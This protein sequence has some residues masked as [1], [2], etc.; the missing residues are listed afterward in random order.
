MLLKWMYGRSPLGRLRTG[1]LPALVVLLAGC[2]DL[3][4]DRA[5]DAGAPARA[6]GWTLVAMPDTQNV[7]SSY[8]EILYA[9]TAWIAAQATA[10]DIRYVVQEGDITNDSTDTQWKTADHAFRLLDDKVPYALAMGNH[11]YPGSG[12]VTSRDTSQFDTYFPPSRLQW[13]PGFVGTFEEGSAVNAMYAF[14]AGGQP[15]LIFTLEFGPR[16]AVLAWVAGMLQN[17]PTAQAILV[18][19]AYLFPDGSRFDHVNRTD[20]YNNPH[21][22]NADGRLGAVNDAEEMWQKLIVDNPAIRLVLCGHM[23]GEA[24]LTSTRAAGPPVHQLLADFQ[25]ESQGGAGYLRMLTFTL[26]GTVSVWT[27]SPYLDRYRTESESQFTL[28]L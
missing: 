21:D 5:L 3:S 6:H 2:G 18:T 25:S 20:Q 12:T 23:H 27:Y 19:H 28:A 13:Q 8:P 26:G 24:R 4:L 1:A 7:V 14:E 15:W 22:Y 9:Q 10:L 17:H 16:D 11:D